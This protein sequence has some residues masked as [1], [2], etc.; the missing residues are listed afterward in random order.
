MLH[1][2]HQ[3]LVSILKIPAYRPSARMERWLLFLQHYVMDIEYTRG[4]SNP[5]D[6]LSRY[7]T[8]TCSSKE[9]KTTEHYI[10]FLTSVPIHQAL[11]MEELASA[12]A[13]D[14]Q[15]Q[16]IITALDTGRWPKDAYTH[17]FQMIQDEL[18]LSTNGILLRNQR[19]V[20]PE[21]LQDR[22]ITL[23]HE[24]HLGM[25]KT[26]QLL[27]SRVWFPGLDSKVKAVIRRCIP[28]QAVGGPSRTTPL[29]MTK[30]PRGRWQEIRMGFVGPFPD[31]RYL[32]AVL[33]EFSRTPVVRTVPST[34]ALPVIQKL[35]EIFSEYG[36]PETVRTDGGPYFNGSVFQ[37]FSH[38]LGFRHKKCTPL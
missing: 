18:S 4:T 25:V 3:P 23:A 35:D 38:H 6:Y 36:V 22:I 27:R 30:L 21:A 7:G 28:C 13:E 37:D 29:R 31:G 9:E 12:T 15:L 33:D 11:T 34:A 5:L 1:T 10:N 8:L 19:L 26:K 24:G 17:K 16:A 2:D 20:I 32:L 14:T